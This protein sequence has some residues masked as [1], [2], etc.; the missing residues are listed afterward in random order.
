MKHK[1]F[2][3][4]AL[5]IAVLLL[6]SLACGS[7]TTE[8]LQDVVVPTATAVKVGVEPTQEQELEEQP[9]D[10]T[11]TE[12]LP[13]ETPLPTDPPPTPTPEPEPI[14]VTN[15]GFGQDGRSV[16]FAFIVEN[17][18]M[19]LA[20]EDSQYQLAAY[21]ENDVVV[22][23][24]SGYINLLLPG[25]S[26]GVGG[27]LFLDEGVTVSKIEVQLNAGNPEPTEPIPTF[28]VESVAY[29][30]GDHFSHATGVINNPYDIDLTNLRVS[31]IVYDETGNII[32]GGYTYQN[33]ILANGSN[34]TEVSVTSAGNVARIE[35]YPTLSSLSLFSSDEELPDGA[36]EI[37]LVNYGFGQDGRRAGFGMIIE[38]PNS[39]YAVENSQYQ[40]T[41]FAT[42]GTVLVTD[43]G[44]INLLLPEQLLGLGGDLFLGE[45][46]EID[47]VEVQ[48][49]A[50]EYVES[51]TIPLFT[52]ENA[53][54]QPGS[55]SSKVTGLVVSPYTSDITNLRVSAIA[56][57]ENGEIIGGGDTYLD[58][59]PA[60]GKAAVEV[61]VTVNGTPF[62]VELF[63]TV[64]SLSDFE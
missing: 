37:Q 20:F 60:N 15:F 19:G 2:Y 34:G 5:A 56:Y 32:G 25:Q 50:G 36:S 52:Y 39:G 43:E 31:A 14:T 13:T 35:L 51:E 42:D 24:D 26:L 6:V 30:A 28:T 12:A 38:N 4:I 8:Q 17:P 22:E 1:N 11:P 47:H 61:S 29:H 40:L 44:Y 57:D 49:K 27:D 58:F 16:G 64:T 46:M 21:D 41:A 33:F 45:G 63:A 53:T 18:N 48:I 7:S 62:S 55:Y 3:H 23:T 9:I 54:Y 59:A 10:V